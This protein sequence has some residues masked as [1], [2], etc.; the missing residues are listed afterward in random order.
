MELSNSN[1]GEGERILGE[2]LRRLIEPGVDSADGVCGVALGMNGLTTEDLVGEGDRC[3]RLRAIGTGVYDKD[4]ME[5]RE[6]FGEA[7]VST[8]CNG[9]CGLVPLVFI[10]EGGIAERTGEG[11]G[12]R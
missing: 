2:K 8:D 9:I 4:G 10:A 3:G 6:V 7:W 11:S 1:D 12:E 5:D